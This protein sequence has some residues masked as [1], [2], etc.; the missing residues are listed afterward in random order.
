MEW[1]KIQEI[2]SGTFGT[3]YKVMNS[4][5]G[6]LA[7]LKIIHTNF[8]NEKDKKR[9]KRGFESASKVNHANCVRMLEWIENEAEVGFLMEFVETQSNASL[10]IASLQEKI[11]KIIQICNGLEA[12]HSQGITHRDLKPENILLTAEGKVKITDFDLLKLDDASALTM[13]GAFIGTAK[14]ASP[15]QCKDASRIDFRSDL[16]SLGVIFYELVTGRIPFNGKNFMEIALGHIRSPLISPRQYSPEL[17]SEIEKIILRLLEK[18]PEK[19]FQTAREVARELDKFLNQGETVEIQSSTDYLLS[20]IFVGREKQ[21]HQLENFYTRVTNRDGQTVIILGESG[22]GKSRLVEEFKI[23]LNLH[24]TLNFS[25]KFRIEGGVFEA[26]QKL[27]LELLDSLRKIS[28]EE[29]AEILGC[30]GYDLIKIAPQISGFSVYKH[31]KALPELNAKEAEFRL[32]DAFKTFLQ[33]YADFQSN[34]LVL[35]FDDLQWADEI[36][37]RCFQ[38]AS[39]NL[40]DSPILLLGTCRKE[41]LEKSSFVNIFDELTKAKSAE[42]IELNKLDVDSISEML[43]SMLG[44]TDSINTKISEEILKQTKGNPLFVQEVMYHLLRNEKLSKKNGA[45][46]FRKEAFQDLILPE[47]VQKVISERLKN[48]D[49]ELREVLQIGAVLGRSFS[50]DTLAEI[51][52]KHKSNLDFYLKEA[53]KKRLIEETESKKFSFFHDAVKETLERDLEKEDFRSL[54]KKAGEKLEENLEETDL[55]SEELANH[56]YKAELPEK[57]IF[58]CEKAGKNS[59]KKFAQKKALQYFSMGLELAEKEHLTS[60]K[61]DF[62]LLKSKIFFETGNWSEAETLL[63][64]LLNDTEID[65]ESMAKLQDDLAWLFLMKGDFEKSAKHYDKLLEI[66]LKLNDKQEI[67]RVTGCKGHIYFYKGDFEKA[68]EFYKKELELS[69]EMNFDFG[70]ARAT[71]NLGVVNHS[72]QN[73]ATAIEYLEKSYKYFEKIGDRTRYLEIVGNL[74]TCYLNIGQIEKAIECHEKYLENYQEMGNSFAVAKAFANLGVSYYAENNYEKGIECTKQAMEISKQIGDRKQVVIV[75]GNLGAISYDYNKFDECYSYYELSVELARE[76]GL[77]FYLADRLVKKAQVSIVLNKIDEAK[78]LLKEGFELS[79]KYE[80]QDLIFLSKILF[81][82]IDFA[83]GQAKIAIKTLETMLFEEISEDEIATL[84]VEIFQ[85][86]KKFIENGETEISLDEV[87]RVAKEALDSI[88]KITKTSPNETRKRTIEDLKKFLFET[89]DSFFQELHS[90]LLT[91]LVQFMSPENAFSELLRFLTVKCQ[92]NTCEII[93]KNEETGELEVSAVSPNLREEDAEFSLTILSSAIENNKPLCIGNA[94]EVSDYQGQTSIAGRQF[95]SV[96]AVPIRSDA[97]VFG[98]IYLDRKNLGFGAFE[99]EDLQKV[100]K[101]ADILTPI[102]I[103]QEEHR[104]LKAKS[105]VSSL[106]LFI[107]VSKKMKNVF[108]QIEKAS[109]VDSTVYI[110]GESGTGKELVAKSL[111]EL[112]PRNKKSFIPVNC[113]AIPKDLAESEFFGHE[114]GSFSGAL[115]TKIGKFELA[116]GGTLLLDEIGELPFD[117]QSKL[118]RAIQER[119][120]WRVGGQKGIPIDVRIV[121]ATNKNLEEEVKKG[122]FREDLFYRLNVIKIDLPPLR[123]RLE[124]VSVLAYH[125]LEKFNSEIQGFTQDAIASLQTLEWKGNVREL[126]NLIEKTVVNHEGNSPITVRELFP[127]RKF[128]QAVRQSSSAETSFFVEGQNLDEQISQLEKLTVEKALENNLGN[129]SN[130]ATELGITRMR[131]DRL[132]E[133]H[134]I[135]FEKKWTKG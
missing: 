28:I 68:I 34:P 54:H 67:A 18:D 91:N 114:K 118:L 51:S 115:A 74:G 42:I 102:L 81:A 117:L 21:L 78:A 100:Q 88:L 103:R 72:F 65:L 82:K 37:S 2:A 126:E 4:N 73:Y 45:W 105:A 110:Y 27:V 101:I 132:I 33:N 87:R 134:S 48:I 1:E 98:A 31:L 70:I 20:P 84:K 36:S 76:L 6:K 111:H 69:E 86:V 85:F 71:A 108:K 64:E 60:K 130:T 58:Y 23:G 12:L 121:I 128:S 89:S 106:G 93:L 133:K 24:K 55:H 75:S 46:D 44:K 104:K 96:I 127:M 41:E 123:T 11:T 129:K 26:F 116:E 35:V 17:P 8:R 50:S 53:K 62:Q 94:V 38:Y 112:S 122:T 80:R 131:L 95:L 57:A 107:G 59:K 90:E 52:P 49:E 92:A 3:V 13:T 9:I 120:I 124:D 22:I 119:Q 25:T 40:K 56:F 7:A 79:Q 5:T 109:R 14:Y 29:Q 83:E 61:R 113:A 77:A 47:T 30:L 97:E 39:R 99:K 63:V 16:Y 32:Y 43:T 19:R 125:F 15:E 66:F 10:Q 135:I